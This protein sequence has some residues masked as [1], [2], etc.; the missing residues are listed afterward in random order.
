M[1][2][3]NDENDLIT[4]SRIDAYEYE[5]SNVV[6]ECNKIILKYKADLEGNNKQDEIKQKFQK[7][8]EKVKNDKE[9]SK[10]DFLN[11]KKKLEDRE[12]RM[13]IDY[14]VLF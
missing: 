9:K 5:L 12:S 6:K 14:E 4:R 10:R 7:L 11:L 1:N 3:R 2:T 13:A 8:E